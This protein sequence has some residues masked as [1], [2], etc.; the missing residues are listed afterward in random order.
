MTYAMLKYGEP[1][2]ERAGVPGDFSRLFPSN[3]IWRLRRGRMSASFFRGATRTM[4]LV[5]GEAELTS[6]KINQS[7]FGVGHFVAENLA[8][9][10][11]LGVLR[12]EGQSRA[13]RP[14]YD[15]P[16]GRPVAPEQWAATVADRQ[17][18]PLAPCTSELRV[19]EVDGGLYIRYRTLDGHPGVT[20]QMAFDFPAGGVWE[21]DDTCL[22]PL[23]GQVLFLKRGEGAM[24]FGNDVI[25]IGPGAHAHA[26][27]KMR[28]SEQA[29][30]H[31]RV[32]LTFVTPVDH[33]VLLRCQRTP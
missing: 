19:R 27:W 25:G 3:G 30:G 23:A 18:R 20:A 32:L 26:M 2:R 12:S 4:T 7:Y 31:V 11:G 1:G 10:E 6:L 22:M 33:T 16:L 8:L 29:P 17:W 24:R 9:A 14:G 21:T 15:M 28:D 5:Y 13:H